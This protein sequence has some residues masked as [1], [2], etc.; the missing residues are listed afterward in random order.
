MSTTSLTR[1]GSLQAD[2]IWRYFP[3]HS[4]FTLVRASLTSLSFYQAKGKMKGV[5]CSGGIFLECS[6]PRKINQL[7]VS[8]ENTIIRWLA[9]VHRKGLFTS[10]QAWDTHRGTP[11]VESH[12]DMKQ[13][14][15]GT[16]S[17][18][19]SE[20]LCVQDLLPEGRFRRAAEPGVGRGGL[21]ATPGLCQLPSRGSPQPSCVSSRPGEEPSVWGLVLGTSPETVGRPATLRDCARLC[22][23]PVQTL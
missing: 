19:R 10:R 16:A 3:F 20:S 15:F 1:T 18:W 11:W 21:A 9:V 6:D 12:S 17:Y 13:S 2:E 4:D 7:K 23:F 14:G 22:V 8:Q 5:P